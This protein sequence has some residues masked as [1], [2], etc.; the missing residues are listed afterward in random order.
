MP[1]QNTAA[2]RALVV[3]MMFLVVGAVIVGP[4]LPSIPLRIVAGVA[5]I[6]SLAL[7]AALAVG[8]RP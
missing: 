6:V 3:A 1:V 2:R 5:T 4:S 7:L 8:R